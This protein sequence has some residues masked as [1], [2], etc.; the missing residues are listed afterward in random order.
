M[1]VKIFTQVLYEF[2]YHWHDETE[3]LFVLKGQCHV[4][5]DR[6]KI[7][8]SEGDLYLINR[9]DVHFIKSSVPNQTVDLLALQFDLEAYA[10]KFENLITCRFQ[11][12]PHRNESEDSVQ[13][14]IKGL[15]AGMM[16]DYIE[17]KMLVFLGLKEVFWT[18]YWNY[19]QII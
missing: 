18:C 16:M 9:G 5:I 7:D 6:H 3:I 11:I 10:D 13:K 8:L 14:K 4:H 12:G 15:M 19:Y 17:K 2:P 1:P